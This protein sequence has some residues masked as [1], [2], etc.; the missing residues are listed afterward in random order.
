MVANE[1][2]AVT[3]RFSKMTWR[4]ATQDE[5]ALLELESRVAIAAR[6]RA[7]L[8]YSELADRLLFDLPSLKEPRRR[9]DAADWQDLDRAIIGDFLGYMSMRSYA[10][11]GFFS[12]ALVV[13]KRDGSPSPG[14]YTLLQDL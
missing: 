7:L 3:E 6:R 14:F 1:M 8:T 11:G 2:D 4:Y 10:I 9:I 12:S 5:A 13:S